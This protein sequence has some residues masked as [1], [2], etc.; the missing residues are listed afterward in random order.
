[1][2]ASSRKCW[3]L[4]YDIR[5]PRRIQRVHA[6]LRK[7]GMPL[8]YSVFGLQANDQELRAILDDI[9][10]L[11][12]PGCDDVRAYHLPDHC[13]VWTLGRQ[14][15]PEGVIVTGVKAMR[16]LARKEGSTFPERSSSGNLFATDCS[17]TEIDD[18]QSNDP[19][20][21]PGD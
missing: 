21:S 10:M 1:M 19:P 13:P 6:Y 9:E 14:A 12:D 16:L 3:L 7:R 5:C 11:I 2:S 4:A 8:Q 17:D 15:M 20:R 18:E